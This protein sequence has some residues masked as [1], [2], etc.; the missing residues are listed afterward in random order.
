MTLM[1]G[2]CNPRSSQMSESKG[3]M[4]SGASTTAPKISSELV[5]EDEA[6]T[7]IVA[8]FLEGLNTRLKTMQ[9]A[10]GSGDFDAL[11]VAAHQLKGSGGG[12]GYPALTEHAARLEQ[13]AIENAIETCKKTVAELDALCA[14]LVVS[15]D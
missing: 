9:D 15:D 8:E 12:Y 7:E 2:V 13:S 4:M 6:F 14:R 10:I 1:T 5:R 3:G 11:R